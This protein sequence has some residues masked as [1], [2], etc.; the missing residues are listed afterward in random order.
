MERIS[1]HQSN[2]R[3]QISLLQQW[4]HDSTIQRPIST[5]EADWTIKNK[6]L[7]KEER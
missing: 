2:L 4:K 5:I 6:E 7:E 1:N 3:K